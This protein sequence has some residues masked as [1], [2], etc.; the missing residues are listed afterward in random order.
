[1]GRPPGKSIGGL[2]AHKPCS[3]RNGL[4]PSELQFLLIRGFRITPL[5]SWAS[6]VALV[7]KNLPDNAG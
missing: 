3:L 5:R 1:M 4:T 6:Q 7:I 2:A